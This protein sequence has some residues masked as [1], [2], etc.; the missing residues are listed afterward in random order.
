MVRLNVRVWI[1]SWVKVI[2]LLMAK[3]KVNVITISISGGGFF[4]FFFF[5]KVR[6][7]A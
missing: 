6:G 2:G 4:F 5:F 3:F 7:L 1:R